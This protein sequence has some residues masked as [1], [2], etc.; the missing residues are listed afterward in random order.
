MPVS[1]LD[2]APL[3]MRPGRQDEAI[4]AFKE[5]AN[6]DNQNP[7]PH[8]RIGAL[9]V[10]RKDYSG[11]AR[12]YTRSLNINPSSIPDLVAL[13]LCYAHGDDY[14]QAEAAFITALKPCSN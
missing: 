4:A 14:A 9:L 2:W 13:G 10:A 3:L 1:T 8:R 7:E 11:A 5:A 12:E 6:L